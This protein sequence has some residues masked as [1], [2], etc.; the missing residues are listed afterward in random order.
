MNRGQASSAILLMLVGAAIVLRTVRG[1][2]VKRVRQVT[3]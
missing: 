1:S 3:R 2:L